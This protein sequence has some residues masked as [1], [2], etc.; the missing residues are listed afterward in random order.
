ML[1]ENSAL[2]ILEN[3]LNTSVRIEHPEYDCLVPN[4]KSPMY[5]WLTKMNG[6]LQAASPAT[7][8][9]SWANSKDIWQAWL[10]EPVINNGLRETSGYDINGNLVDPNNIWDNWDYSLHGIY[11][12]L[13]S[14][15]AKGGS[16]GNFRLNNVFNDTGMCSKIA[17]FFNRVLTSPNGYYTRHTNPSELVY[18]TYDSVHNKAWWLT[19]D[20]KSPDANKPGLT[21]VS[22]SGNTINAHV[23]NV[24][25][26]TLDLS[27]M[28]ID[29][30][31][32]KTLT[33][34][35]DK[36]TAPYESKT[37]DGDTTWNS[38]VTLNLVGQWYPDAGYTVTVNGQGVPLS[39]TTG[40]MITIPDIQLYES[41]IPVQVTIPGNL[42]D[43]KF[44]N[45]ATNPVNSRWWPIQLWGGVTGTFQWDTVEQG[46][47]GSGSVKIRD[48][49][50]S[51]EPYLSLWA[52]SATDYID[53]E[54][55]EYYTASAFVRTRLLSTNDKEIQNGKYVEPYPSKAGVGILWYRSDKSYLGYTLSDGICGTN[56]WTPQD[57]TNIEP[58][59]EAEYAKLVLFIKDLKD[60]FIQNC[61]GSSGSAWFDD[62]RFSRSDGTN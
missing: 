14:D 45:F 35:L 29:T 37:I 12:D 53:V 42:V 59:D 23:K 39:T 43:M 20:I 49:K 6:G 17:S 26:A 18:K 8:S 36:N 41:A 44:D 7:A 54:Q 62:V 47:G 5:I 13:N 58:P 3:G 56:D 4:T 19:M 40:T 16:H 61:L 50:V 22:V 60:P 25:S 10:D 38:K 21:K 51:G 31:T 11:N 9:A 15:P 57:I 55:G 24:T 30:T 33:F 32:P 48:V 34:N 2:Y 28:G 52:P 27:R 46:H 1:R